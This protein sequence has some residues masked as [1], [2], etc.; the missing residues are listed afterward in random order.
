MMSTRRPATPS[1][2]RSQSP[3]RRRLVAA[4]CAA[5]F[6]TG[7]CSANGDGAGPGFSETAAAAAA[8]YEYTIPAG[9]GVALDE[10]TPLTILPGELEVKVGET[11]KIVNNDDR[12]HNVGPWFVGAGETLRQ[13]FTSEGSFEGNCTVHPSGTLVLRVLAT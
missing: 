6:L 2:Q 3:G 10:G 7:A 8:N 13:A 4:I 5:V 9:A 11:I 1:K 12:G